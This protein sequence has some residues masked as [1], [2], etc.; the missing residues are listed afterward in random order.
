MKEQFNFTSLR[1]IYKY[2]YV[3]FKRSFWSFGIS[4]DKVKE[5]GGSSRKRRKKD[6]KKETRGNREEKNREAVWLKELI[7]KKRY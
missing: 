3:W 5:G 7:G 2:I 1:D 6:F 4:L